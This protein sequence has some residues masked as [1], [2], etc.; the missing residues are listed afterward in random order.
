ME[1]KGNAAITIA[2]SEVMAQIA[3]VRAEA[4][5]YS[6]QVRAKADRELGLARAEGKRLKAD[7]LT[8]S[9]GRYVVALETA[10]MFENIDGAVMTPEQYIAFVRNAW[11]LI[12]LSPG[13]V[14]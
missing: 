13:G 1:S 3:K 9:G 7:A 11:A 5:L 12:G 4:E 14:R 8:Q 2:E 6:S 10:K